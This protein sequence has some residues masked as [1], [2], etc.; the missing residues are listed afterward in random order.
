M[1]R[2]NLKT[3][4]DLDHAWEEWEVG[5][6]IQRFGQFVYNKFCKSGE[7]WPEL[8]YERSHTKA[9]EIAAAQLSEEQ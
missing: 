5:N 9:F 1:K 4:E 3:V 7:P 2:L 8:F 6:K